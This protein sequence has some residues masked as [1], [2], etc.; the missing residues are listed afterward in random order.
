MNAMAKR[1]QPDIRLR[2]RRRPPVFPR[3][4]PALGHL[5][6]SAQD[7]FRKAGLVCLHFAPFGC[8]SALLQCNVSF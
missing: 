8:S 3:V 6:Q 2:T 4:K 1:G 7:G 5:E